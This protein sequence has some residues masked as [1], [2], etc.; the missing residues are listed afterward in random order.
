ML[1]YHSD[2]E[3]ADIYAYQSGQWLTP[4]MEAEENQP[5]GSYIVS[6]PDVT[7]DGDEIIGM[8]SGNATIDYIRFDT[9]QEAVDRLQNVHILL[10]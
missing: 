8:N 4:D 1:H 5:S 3:S 2:F 10:A 9:R 6:Q 7:I